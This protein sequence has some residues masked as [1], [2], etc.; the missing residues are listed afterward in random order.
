MTSS[1][2]SSAEP[3]TTFRRSDALTAPLDSGSCAATAATTR[4]PDCGTLASSAARSASRCAIRARSAGGI[5]ARSRGAPL[6]LVEDRAREVVGGC[7]ALAAA[8]A[9]AAR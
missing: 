3:M 7:G 9:C 4:R 1:A 8:S 2:A 6:D 5:G